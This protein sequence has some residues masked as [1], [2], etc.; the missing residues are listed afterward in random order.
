MTEVSE[1]TLETAVNP[2]ANI[3]LSDIALEKTGFTPVPAGDYTF[4]IIPGA[5]YRTRQFPDGNSV[6]ELNVQA[7][8][9]EGDHKGR[10]VF[11][12]YPDPTSTNKDGKP[13]AWSKQALKKLEIV[14]GTDAFDGEDSAA[15]LNRVATTTAARFAA[16][17]KQGTYIKAGQTEAEPELN[18]W[19]VRPA[20]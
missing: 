17:L 10:R 2:W 5:Q 3:K 20:A 19:S 15:Y 9:A 4:Q 14:L 6:T 7:A 12:N 18:L 11:F 8:V 13:K 16:T 1:A